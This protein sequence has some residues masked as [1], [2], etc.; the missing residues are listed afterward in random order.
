MLKT[1]P[2]AASVSAQ[3]PI[4]PHLSYRKALYYFPDLGPAGGEAEV[5]ILDTTLIDRDTV[6]K[7]I[8]EAVATLPAK[9]YA[10]M[11]DQDGILL[12]ERRVRVPRRS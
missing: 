4:S 2:P 9:G 7:T 8:A 5:V 6:R 1:T 3:T 12:F 11:L 10:K